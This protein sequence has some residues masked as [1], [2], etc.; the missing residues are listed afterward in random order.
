MKDEQED[1]N[2]EVQ[3]IPSSTPSTESMML[4]MAVSTAKAYP[5]NVTR[6]INDCIAIATMDEESAAKCSYTLPF[7]DDKN[8]P[9]SG[10]SVYLARIILQTWTNL[11]AGARVVGDDGKQIT[12]MGLCWDME[13]NT[14][15]EIEIKR[16]V[17]NKYGKRYTDRMVSTTSNASNAIAL[18]NALFSI[19]PASVTDKILREAKSKVLG[20]VSTQTKFIARRKQIFDKLRDTY[21]VTEEE[22]LKSIDRVSMEHV[23]VDD[24][25]DLIGIGTAIKDGETSID[26]AFRGVKDG[27]KEKEL[28]VEELAALF[29]EKKVKMDPKTVAD[30]IRIL[31]LEGTVPEKNSFKKLQKE[32]LK[33]K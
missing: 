32:L 25:S 10:P 28:T 6:C 22:I 16:S 19:I 4:N 12:S 3:V 24:L 23:T 20:D 33:I 11:R 27:E 18:R 17:I 8:K 1:T 31:G 29:I 14:F 9:I 26:E 2:Y 5:R 21:N 13:K 15:I 30:A 7:K